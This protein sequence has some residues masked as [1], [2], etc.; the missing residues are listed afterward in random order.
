VGAPLAADDPAAARQRMVTEQIAS[1]GVSDARVLA[2][3]RKVPC[4]GFVPEVMR[5]SA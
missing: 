5:A 4:H 2:A 1:R 3:M